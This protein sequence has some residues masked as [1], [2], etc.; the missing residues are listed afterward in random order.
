METPNILWICTD[1]QRFDTLGC[2]GNSFVTTPNINQLAREGAL[3][4]NAFCQS[5]V[6]TPSRGSFLTGRYPTTCGTRQNGARIPDS[7][8]LI[9]R[10]LHDNGYR[11]GLAGKLHLSAC[12][13]ESGCTE[14]ERRI[15]DGYDE[16]HWSHDP[17]SLWGCHNEYSAWLNQKGVRFDTLDRP[18]S[19]WVQTGM[20][21]EHHQTAWC[22][23]KAVDF[24]RSCTGRGTPWLFSVNIFDPHHPFDPPS[25]YLAP[26]LE[27]L[28][29]VP[30]PNYTPGELKDKSTWHREDSSGAYGHRGLY[31]F[32]E[33]SD[34]N[35]RLVRAAYWAM[36][37]LI[38]VQVGRMLQALEQTGQADNTIVIFTSDH[39][40]MLGD[41]GVYLKG[42]YFY[43]CAVNVPL[44]IRWPRGFE[45]GEYQS[46]VELVDLPQTLLDLIGLEHHPGMQG[47]SFAGILK[48]VQPDYHRSSV[49]CEY[50]NAMPWHK[51]P[52][53]WSTM[54]RD[55][56][57]KI[58]QHHTDS[59][60]ELYDLM[61]DPYEQA[62]LWFDPASIE[63][64]VR[65][66]E[67]MACR[68]SLTAD[69]LPVRTG[70]W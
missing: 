67:L 26:Y 58:V 39:G 54:V 41:H 29:E 46:F 19:P 70:P 11:C 32:T 55:E 28:D 47:K 9:S 62:N 24:I 44:I 23:E 37:D 21:E 38:D 40:E 42:H 25:D 61:K 8:V 12:S 3:F 4:R 36:C 33:M 50:Y 49:Y 13:P 17:T 5:P 64:K 59:V 48:G 20:P 30:L 35:H 34:G 7:E 2:Y 51:E 65:M 1:Q 27:K 22:A 14:V 68:M 15:N 43:E 60:G 6:C 56:R 69:P 10:I 53:A 52:P 31:P 18:D 57:F 16:F 66:L 45:A 63:E